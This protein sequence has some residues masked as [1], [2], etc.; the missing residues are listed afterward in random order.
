M[1]LPIVFRVKAQTEFDGQRD[2]SAGSKSF[3]YN[4][5]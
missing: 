5:K 1:S 3:R 2:R 4:A